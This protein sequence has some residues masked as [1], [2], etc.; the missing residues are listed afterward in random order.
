MY[1]EDY[2]HYQETEGV[3]GIPYSN[4]TWVG[5]VLFYNKHSN[6]RLYEFY[7]VVWLYKYN[8]KTG[9][10]KSEMVRV[11]SSNDLNTLK[12]C[13]I[14]CGYKVDW[15]NFTVAYK[16]MSNCESAGYPLVQNI[17]YCTATKV[18]KFL[19]I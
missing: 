13:A 11:L 14:N 3:Y 5:G 1:D 10:A 7:G 12:S 16:I 17:D 4:G 8:K 18:E 15:N 9:L 2:L 6:F 19:E